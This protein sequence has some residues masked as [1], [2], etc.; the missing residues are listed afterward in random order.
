MLGAGA[1]DFLV[2]PVLLGALRIRPPIPLPDMVWGAPVI[3]TMPAGGVGSL[4][5]TSPM[6]RRGGGKLYDNWVHV[7]MVTPPPAARTTQ[8]LKQTRRPQDYGAQPTDYEGDG[9]APRGLG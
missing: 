1:T 3:Y 8:E 9:K 4:D 2:S 7:G 6:R 5:P